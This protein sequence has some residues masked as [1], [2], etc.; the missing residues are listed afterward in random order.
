MG[1]VPGL[2][3][4]GELTGHPL[5]T[6]PLT[7]WSC[8]AWNA[9]WSRNTLGGV[10]GS[11]GDGA[12]MG[13][14]GALPTVS[15]PRVGSQT[16]RGPHL[17]GAFRAQGLDSGENLFAL[18]PSLPR[19]KTRCCHPWDGGQGLTPGRSQLHMQRQVFMPQ[20]EAGVA[21]R[22]AWGSAICPLPT[23]PLHSPVPAAPRA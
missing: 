12:G 11:R 15:K 19:L 2:S 13:A 17:E 1:A 21:H 20:T 6:H 5:S 3:S 14:Q 8:W 16:L 22:Q 7:L 9:N 4:C 18:Q 23:T 10:K